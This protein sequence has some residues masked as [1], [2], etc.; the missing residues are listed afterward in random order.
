MFV[1]SGAALLTKNELLNITQKEAGDLAA[2]LKEIAKHHQITIDPKTQAYAELAIVAGMIY[3]P[4][5]LL[6]MQAK[7][8]AKAAQVPQASSGANVMPIQTP[9][10]GGRM[11]FE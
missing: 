5:V 10:N 2:A 6:T 3:T 4:R 8:Q 9:P 7:K 1:H 11:R